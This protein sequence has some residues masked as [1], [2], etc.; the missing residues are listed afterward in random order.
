MILALYSDDL[1]SYYTFDFISESNETLDI[2][3]GTK[4]LTLGAANVTHTYG[5]I[6]N[7]VCFRNMQPIDISLDKVFCEDDENCFVMMWLN[8]YCE[9][10]KENTI[11][12]SQR[13]IMQCSELL[14]ENVSNSVID[15]ISKSKRW[16]VEIPGGL[17]HHFAFKTTSGGN[18]DIY[19]NGRL[20]DPI[21]KD[22]A[23]TELS[24][25]NFEIGGMVE[26]CLDE[27]LVTTVVRNIDIEEVFSVYANGKNYK[28]LNIRFS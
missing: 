25:S 21:S 4:K 17:W 28:F 2:I 23:D 22:P 18:G 11:I 19:V 16:I 20:I 15:V 9:G 6:N 10:G 1:D 12:S 7:A 3:S 24:D 14:P 5:V 27:V 26:L 13:F 8:Y